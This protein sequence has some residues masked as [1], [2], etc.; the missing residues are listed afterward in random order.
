MGRSL[1]SLKYSTGGALVVQYRRAGNVDRSVLGYLNGYIHDAMSLGAT[2]G[3]TAL[4]KN[5][6]RHRLVAGHC[7]GVQHWVYLIEKNLDC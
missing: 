5:I 7:D 4:P 6:A 3:D 2:Q 1:L